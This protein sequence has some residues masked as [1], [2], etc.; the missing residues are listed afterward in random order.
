MDPQATQT[1][2]TPVS[3]KG[4]QDNNPFSALETSDDEPLDSLVQTPEDTDLLLRSSANGTQVMQVEM[5]NTGSNDA[6][7]EVVCYHELNGP[8]RI[9]PPEIEGIRRRIKADLAETNLPEI[10]R[11]DFAYWL[12]D[13][14]IFCA[15]YAAQF[16]FRGD[17]ELLDNVNIMDSGVV[18]TIS[19]KEKPLK[20]SLIV[21][22]ELHQN[23]KRMGNSVN[24]V[25]D[26]APPPGGFRRD[27]LSQHVYQPP[28]RGRGPSN[29]GTICQRLS[30]NY[31]LDEGARR[32]TP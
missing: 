32:S 7:I 20:L 24:L 14:W 10:V 12:W 28:P 5:T 2:R 18:D 6:R 30:K 26:Q 15:G 27:H 23:M 25:T 13:R 21:G 9:W 4:P 11:G 16:T 1:K 22:S 19:T 3:Q 17:S 29:K 8:A 31:S